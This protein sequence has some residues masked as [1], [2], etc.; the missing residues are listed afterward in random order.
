MSLTS[1]EK[2]LEVFKANIS[3]IVYKQK[4]SDL[5][6]LVFRASAEFM[7]SAKMIEKLIR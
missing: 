5:L 4:L 3:M 2:T 7:K 1:R 6:P